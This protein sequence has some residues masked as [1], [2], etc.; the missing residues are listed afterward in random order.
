MPTKAELEKLVEELQSDLRRVRK[1][2]YEHYMAATAAQNKLETREQEI[3]RLTS[4]NDRKAKRLT[5]T[6]AKDQRRRSLMHKWLIVAASMVGLS[7]T[8]SIMM[9]STVLNEQQRQKLEIVVSQKDEGL[10]ARSGVPDAPP[11]SLEPIM[12]SPERYLASVRIGGGGGCSGTIIAI[13][14][15]YAYGISAQHCCYGVGYSVPFGN[16]DGSTGNLRWIAEDYST[17]LALFRCWSRDVLGCAKV[18][19]YLRP[20]WSKD[21]EGV[22]YPRGAGPKYKKLRYLRTQS[23]GERGSRRH[24]YNR[25]CFKNEGPGVFAGG[26]SGGGVFYD[27][28]YLIGVMTHGSNVRAASLPQIV[29][30]LDKHKAKFEGVDQYG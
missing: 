14:E 10:A 28:D 23:H 29:A 18:P 27:G 4:E 15:K 25:Y 21:T 19:R 1:R 6:T 13:G 16:P 11:M 20:N 3:A 2:R 7:I 26:D 22:G 5:E 9:V 24:L 17:D 12:R 30:F 8:A